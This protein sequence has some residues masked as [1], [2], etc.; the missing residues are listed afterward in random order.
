[1]PRLID[2][3]PPISPAISVWPGDVPFSQHYLCRMESGANLDLSSITTTVHLGA[4]TDGPNHYV[5]GGPG[6]GERDLSYYYGP[7]QVIEVAV[8]RG[9]RILPDHI[10]TGVHAPRVL[11]KTGTFPDPNRW[12][13]DFAALS[14]ELVATLHDQGVV[15]VG[16]DTPSVDPFQSKALESHHAIADR[17]MAILEG[18]VL[19]HVSPGAYTLIALPLPLVGADA[20]PVRA[21]LVSEAPDANA[22]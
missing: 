7:C 3:S 21:V 19:D 11:F 12:N 8:K 1:M 14:P 13:D 10:Q 22:H 16:L 6:I 15:L 17:D 9:Q 20:S 18:V 2:I 5:Q 4:H